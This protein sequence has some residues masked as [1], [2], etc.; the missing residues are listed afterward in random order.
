M[1]F[2]YYA[3]NVSISLVSG[4][5]IIEFNKGAMYLLG[6]GLGAGLLVLF[7]IH[8]LSGKEISNSY[9]RKATRLASVFI[10]L[11][12]VFPQLVD[13]AVSSRVISIGYVFCENSSYR[14]LHVQEKVFGINADAC[15]NIKTDE[16][17]KS[18][19]GR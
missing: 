19:G 17:T 3:L 18:S 14:W 13:Y 5:D 9:N 12:F 11:I 8:E 10:G 6:V 7:M 2:G 16:I 4:W 1:A 15:V